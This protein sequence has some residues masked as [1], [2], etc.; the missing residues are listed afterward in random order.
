[1]AFDGKQGVQ[2]CVKRVKIIGLTTSFLGVSGPWSV[3][4]GDVLIHTDL[5]WA[6]GEKVHDP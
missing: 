1:M 4:G 3:S 5:L 2:S 6:T